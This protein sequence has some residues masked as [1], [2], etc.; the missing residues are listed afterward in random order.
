MQRRSIDLTISVVSFN[1]FNTAIG[2]FELHRAS[3]LNGH[4]TSRESPDMGRDRSPH[5]GDYLYASSPRYA[6]IDAWCG[7]VIKSYYH[8]D[9]AVEVCAI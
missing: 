1:E 6:L 7:I 8:L 3:C 2:H 4:Q 5:A 9:A